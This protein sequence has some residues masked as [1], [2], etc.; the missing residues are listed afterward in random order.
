MV[1]VTQNVVVVASTVI[2]SLLYMVGLNRVWPWEKRHPYN[3]IIGWRLGV[4]GTTFAVILGFMLYTVWSNLAEAD[5]NVDRD[6]NAAIDVYQLANGMPDSTPDVS[7][8]LRECG[9]HSGVARDGQGA[10]TGTKRGPQRTDVEDRH[11]GES[12]L[13]NRNQYPTERALRA[14]FADAT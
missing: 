1:T 10:G 12:D 7:A 11:V 13:S 9:H 6:A 3:D 14:E 5:L 8:L 4:L 2:G